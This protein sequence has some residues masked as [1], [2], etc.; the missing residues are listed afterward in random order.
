M[1]SPQNDTTRRLSMVQSGIGLMSGKGVAMALG[2]LYWLLAARLYPADVVGIVAAAIA[3][4]MLV[5][6]LGVFGLESAIVARY[7]E[8][9]DE[10]NTFFN[11]GF[12][13][14]ALASL[15]VAV[16]AAVVAFVIAGELGQVVRDE[17]LLAMFIC[18]SVVAAVGIVLDQVS[19]AL[20]RGDHVVP[21]NTTNGLV[22]IVPLV[23]M[24]VLW[25]SGYGGAT[26]L[27]GS[28]FLGAVSGL[29]LGVWQLSRLKPS[30]LYRPQ[31]LR[32]LSMTLVRTGLPN[33]ILTLTERV[34]VL[35]IPLL[36]AELISPQATAYWYAV[37]MVAW[38]TLVIARSMSFALF[39][40]TSEAGADM[41]ASVFKAL[42]GSLLLGSLAAAAT[43][44]AAPWVLSL[45]GP[46]YAA[47]GTT[48]LR[49]LVLS[50]APY[51]VIM[52]YFAV[53][54]ATDRLREAIIFGVLLATT[55]LVFATSATS[56]GL[57]QVA[58][59]WLVSVSIFSIAA[60]VR[61]MAMVGRTGARSSE[62]HIS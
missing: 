47:A 15:V 12:T 3:G 8:H 48:P 14:V 51:S 39:A 41:A 54:R 20:K 7:S 16:I 21:R 43:V 22:S 13:L 44:V 57:T 38:A 26:V 1:P 42:R 33:H 53:C 19:M 46:D 61:L 45:L 49:I 28:W 34:P 31:V 5:S 17:L 11:T 4:V 6:Q 25:S 23:S 32:G 2:F 62:S 59:A 10:R 30:Y 55:V 50:F 40:E 24:W 37:W 60:G 56:G 9:R 18:M 58:L 36:I 27:F 35:V 29:L 52:T